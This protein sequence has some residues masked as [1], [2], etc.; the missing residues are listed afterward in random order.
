MPIYEYACR[1]CGHGFEAL[2]RGTA[3]PVCPECNATDLDRVFS[4]PAIASASTRSVIKRDI[5]RR[6]HAQAVDRVQ[7]Q[8]TYEKNH[9]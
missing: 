5:Q 4:L 3:A 9:D 6:D 7:A 2:V 1:G 8:R